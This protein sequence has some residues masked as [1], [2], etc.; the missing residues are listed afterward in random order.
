MKLA[1]T[2]SINGL[3]LYI[4]RLLK[5]SL[6]LEGSIKIFNILHPYKYLTG[7]L[8]S[9]AQLQQTGLFLKMPRITKNLAGLPQ[10][11][12]LTFNLTPP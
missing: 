12:H 10:L 6:N 5:K 8:L 4:S 7:R 3:L 9:W 2:L 11:K 1:I